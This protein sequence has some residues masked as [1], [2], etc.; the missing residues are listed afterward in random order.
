MQERKVL[1][2]TGLIYPENYGPY[3]YLAY[4]ESLQINTADI[5]IDN[6][7]EHYNGYLNVLKDGIHSDYL[8]KLMI[9]ITFVD[10]ETLRLSAFDYY[11]NLFMWYVLVASN[12]PIESMHV[13]YDD[14]LTQDSIKNYIDRFLID[15]NRKKI[16]NI[17]LNNIIDDATDKPH[18]IDQFALYLSNT[19]CLEDSLHLMKK[20]PEFR[21]CMNLDI[22]GVQLEDVKSVGMK[23]AYKSIDIIKSSKDILGYDHCLADAFRANQGVNPKQYKET[24]INIGTKP[25][26][27]GGVFPCAINKSFING[28]TISPIDYFIDAH[29]ARTAQIIKLKNVGTSGTFARN[30]G[31]NNLDSRLVSDPNYDCRSNHYIKITINSDAALKML[32]NRYYKMRPAGQD[33]L[34]NYRRDKDLVGKTIYLRSPVTCASAAAGKG[35]CYKCYGDLAY[36]VFDVEQGFGINIGRL[37]SELVSAVLTQRLIGAK[38]ILETK[39]SKITWCE[40]FSSFFE[41]VDNVIKLLPDLNYKDFRLIIDPDSIEL[42]ND[43]DGDLDDDEASYDIY[44]EYITSFDVLQVSTGMEFHITSDRNEELFLTNELNSIVRKKAEPVD[45]KI[46]I[47]FN[48]LKENYLFAMQIKNNELT[49]T[50]NRLLEILNKRPVTE[51]YPGINSLYQDLLDAAIDGGLG[52]IAATHIEVILSNQIR[53]ANNILEKPKWW[54]ATPSYKIIT[55]NE[56]LTNNP[57][58][59]V[60]MSYQKI[61]KMFYAPLTFKKHGASFLDLFFMECPQRVIYDVPEEK[62]FTR[63]PGEYIDPMVITEDPNKIT[64]ADSADSSFDSD[65]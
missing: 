29:T 21:E 28:G 4:G 35:I 46:S 6:W 8:H 48:E 26:G 1:E 41:I 32:H 43:E 30:L 47:S 50:L 31:L 49:K 58:V 16:S 23:Y 27:R 61:K 10:G 34:L 2:E 36:T 11:T 12:T 9:P 52:D 5:N 37:A 55:L 63:I 25:D 39:I 60:S 38:H 42:E 3:A 20:S 54:E 51:A 64:V 18:D 7:E 59:I 19:L 22:S 65:E 56:A 14:E 17:V 15:Q 13:F 62:R 24:Q 57:S 53:D 40:E 44:N 33:L 45:G